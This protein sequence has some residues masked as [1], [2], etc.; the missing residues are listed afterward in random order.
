MIR[1][2]DPTPAAGLAML[3]R[4]RAGPVV[5]LNL[6]RFRAVADYG[7][8]PELAPPVPISGAAAY[9]RYV[10]HTLPYLHRSGGGVI[11]D[12]DGGAWLVGPDGEH[13]DRALLVRQASLD[14]F[15]AFAGDAAYGAG[16]GHRGAALLDSRLL[17]LLGRA[18]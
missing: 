18:A 8:A 11:G 4:G 10:A 6:L 15:M 14:A 2:I 17:P 9:D 3:R 13:W 7:A 5:M 16:L 12:F 1:H